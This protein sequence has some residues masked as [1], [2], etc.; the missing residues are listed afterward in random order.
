MLPTLIIVELHLV[1]LREG[2]E[3]RNFSFVWRIVWTCRLQHEE[4][5]WEQMFLLLR[6]SMVEVES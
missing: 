2:G 6:G 1:G 5:T 4:S 3:L